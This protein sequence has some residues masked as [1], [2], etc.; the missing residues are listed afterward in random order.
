[1]S[2]EYFDKNST[3]TVISLIYNGL[4]QKMNDEYRGSD[5]YDARYITM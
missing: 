5:E 1:M 4:K 2:S 3:Y